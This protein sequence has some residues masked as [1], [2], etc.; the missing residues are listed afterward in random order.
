[1]YSVY[2]LP[3]NVIQAL[4]ERINSTDPDHC[5]SIP[6]GTLG[7]DMFAQEAMERLRY[8]PVK[9]TDKCAASIATY[10]CTKA[11]R[12][13]YPNVLPFC[14]D[15]C[16]ALYNDYTCGGYTNFTT[17]VFGHPFTYIPATYEE[18]IKGSV[19]GSNCT[20]LSM[21]AQLIGWQWVG[22]DGESGIDI[23]L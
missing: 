4:N 7:Y 22:P 17:E 11:F 12:S 23:D 9:L 10:I 1:M 19:S 21:T 5:S 15:V 6:E 20:A 16:T 8:Q 14:S 18:C 13:P 2:P 3:G